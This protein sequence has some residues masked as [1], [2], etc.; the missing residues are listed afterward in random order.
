LQSQADLAI[1]EKE[2]IETW[3][4]VREY[5]TEEILVT[6]YS[7]FVNDVFGAMH[8][9]FFVQTHKIIHQVVNG[10]SSHDRVHQTDSLNRTYVQAERIV[11][12]VESIFKT[13]SALSLYEDTLLLEIPYSTLQNIISSLLTNVKIVYE[14]G[15]GLI[16]A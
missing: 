3:N 16:N 8:I 11:D 10:D 4:A 6:V 9:Q 12:V 5:K 1:V 2:L 15:Q 13:S 7:N 14:Q